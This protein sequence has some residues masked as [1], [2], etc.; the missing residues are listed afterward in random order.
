MRHTIRPT[1]IRASAGTGKTY[2]LV[3]RYVELL[4]HG[5]PADQ[6]LATTFTKKAAGEIR[7]RVLLKLA[8]ASSD[9]SLAKTMFMEIAAGSQTAWL[10]SPQV[11]AQKL[12]KKVVDSQFRLNICTLDSFFSQI[13]RSFSLE[14]GLPLDWKILDRAREQDFFDQVIVALC[15]KSDPRIFAELVRMLNQGFGKRSIHDHLQR[16]LLPLHEVYLFASE[17]A[18]NWLKVIPVATKEEL[19]IVIEELSKLEI[20]KTKK[21][22]PLKV[23]LE[24]VRKIVEAVRSNDWRVFLSQGLVEKVI[25]SENTFARAEIPEEFSFLIKKLLKVA[26]A[27][28]IS[29]LNQQNKAVLELLSSFSREY[30]EQRITSASLSFYDV[31]FVL[32]QAPFMHALEDIFF[33]LD[34]Q[35]QHLMLDE[36]QDTSQLEWQIL[37]P[38]VSE[39]LGQSDTNRTFFCVGDVKQ[40]IYGWRGGVAEIFDSL[41]SRWPNIDSDSLNLSYRCSPCI[42]EFVNQIFNNLSELELL[43]EFKNATNSW[44]KNFV[45]QLAADKDK[46][47]FVHVHQ[48]CCESIQIEYENLLAVELS[49]TEAVYISSI[50]EL[51]QRLAKQPG[52]NAAVLLSTNKEVRNYV[53]LLKQLAPEISVSAEGG[54]SV[55]AVPIIQALVCFLKYL[56]HPNDSV[57]RF[58][59]YHTPLAKIIGLVDFSCEILARDL[60]LS[61][62]KEMINKGAVSFFGALFIELKAVSSN[63]EGVLLDRILEIIASFDFEFFPRVSDLVKYLEQEP[64]S[65]ANSAQLRVMTIHKSKGLEFDIVYLPDLEDVLIGLSQELVLVD[66]ADPFSPPRKII[67]NP[68]KALRNLNQDLAL[69]G[70]QKEEE[71]LKEAFCVLYVALTRA[72]FELGVWFS[73]RVYKENVPLNYKNIILGALNIGAVGKDP[74]FSLG[75]QNYDKKLRMNQSEPS[76]IEKMSNKNIAFASRVGSINRNLFRAQVSKIGAQVLAEPENKQTQFAKWVD[77]FTERSAAMERGLVWH[78]CLENIEWLDE[79]QF[80]IDIVDK[81]CLGLSF[82]SKQVYL[83][84]FYELLN[85]EK[86]R[87]LLSQ[88][89]YKSFR[90]DKILIERELPLIAREQASLLH[91]R[92]DRLVFIENLGKLEFVEIIDF[93][94]VKKVPRLE[95]VKDWQD[96]KYLKDTGY[97]KQLATYSDL[98]SK[99]WNFPMEKIRQTLVFIDG[100]EVEILS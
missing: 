42:L 79:G 51:K 22:E 58:H 75:D 40:A 60:A 21:Q 10:K 61:L 85:C 71:Q 7:E 6:I 8:Q 23:W 34:T 18:W 63:S 76:A 14:L 84:E 54:G 68:P 55:I 32:G 47:G 89:R 62:R 24:A 43:G 67:C 1:V 65:E 11:E 94:S 52:L 64:I 44:C 98:I 20:P 66:R 50:L 90:S 28:L 70:K 72:K 33:R 93:K 48:I 29:K 56:D 69:M 88:S 9:N 5:V 16:Y 97:T 4:A 59:I 78:K 82:K 45:N 17:P 99:L 39:I 53:D 80:D 31:K 19:A 86:F 13:S 12:L 25:N 83:Q 81:Q 27:V 96:S 38:I 35:I 46:L 57:S 100:K 30:F 91:A 2:A 49:K 74:L 95:S 36:F 77:G 41:E 73:D 15:E 87:L 26:E 3:Q 92:I 37:Q